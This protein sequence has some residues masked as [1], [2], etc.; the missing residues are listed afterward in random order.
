MNNRLLKYRDDLTYPEWL[1]EHSSSLKE[2]FLSFSED[3]DDGL[4]A[5]T[6]KGFQVF[7]IEIY[8]GTKHAANLIEEGY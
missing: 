4:R 5:V 3:D 8:L 7:T 6:E 1:S 2:L